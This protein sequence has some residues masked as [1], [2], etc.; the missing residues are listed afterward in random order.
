MIVEIILCILIK[1]LTLSFLN[2][3]F[4]EKF[5]F[6]IPLFNTFFFIIMPQ[7]N[8]EFDWLKED[9]PSSLLNVL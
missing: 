4:D 1:K 6:F 3:H 2:F 9:L 8:I 5:F 7:E